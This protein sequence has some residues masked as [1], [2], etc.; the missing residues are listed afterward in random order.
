MES[1]RALARFFEHRIGW[2]RVGFLLSVTIIAVA[3]VVLY[4]KLHDIDGGKV[5]TAMATVE[6][7]ARRDRRAVRRRRLFHADL[8]RSVRAAHGRPRD[9]P[10]RVAALAGFT[11]YSVGH[12]VGASAFTGGAVR[13]RIYSNWNLDAVEVAKVCFIAGLTFWLGNAT[14]LGFGIAAHPEAASAINQLP[15]WF[16]R[17]LGWPRCGAD[18]LRHLGLAE[19]AH[20]RP[21]EL[22]GQ[23]PGGPLTL[24]QIFIGIVDLGCCSLAMYVLVPTSRI[25]ASTP[26]R[27]VRRRHAARLCQPFA[28]R[29]RRVRRRHAGGALAVRYRGAARRVADL[30]A[31]LLHPAVHAGACDARPARADVEHGEAPRCRRL[32][33]AIPGGGAAGFGASSAGPSEPADSPAA[34]PPQPARDDGL[35]DAVIAGMPDPVVVLDGMGASWRSTARPPRWRRRCGAASRRSLALRCRSWSR[36]SAR[37]ARAASRSASSSRCARPRALVGGLRRAHAFDAGRRAVPA[38]PWSPSTTSRRSAASRRCAP[39]S[40]PTPATNCARRSRP[41]PGFIDTLQ[42]R[43]RDDPPRAS[44]FLGIMQEQAWR[45]ARL[46]DDLL[47]LSRIE[48]RAHQRPETPVDLVP[49]VRQVVDGL[50][51]LARDRGVDRSRSRHRP[52]R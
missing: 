24:L 41:S 22:A 48:L 50:Q 15:E 7:R 17:G 29:A 51:M 6:Y 43:A 33:A 4:R 47:S 10:Y 21:A 34:V 8:L 28:R 1:L 37:P 49:I 26:W 9:V 2:H 5:L 36:R 12:N 25:S 19:A 16:N 13:Y 30:P 38:P 35:L 18:R 39:I 27:C 14:V 44:E 45:M 42:G 40:S 52:S 20:D 3:A 31:A 32:T 23:L 11:S 46:I